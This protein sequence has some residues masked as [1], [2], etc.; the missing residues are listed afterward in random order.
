MRSRPPLLRT[1]FLLA[2]AFV[3]VVVLVLCF[4]RI[5]RVVIGDG[6]FVGPSRAVRAPRAGVLAEVL[7]EPGTRVEAGAVLARLDARGFESER[8]GLAAER[9]GAQTR[10]AELARERQ[11]V[12]DVRHP[13]ERAEMERAQRAAVLVLEAAEAKE[14]R[15]AEL[16][17]QGLVEQ[18]EFEAAK[19]A[20]EL[21]AVELEQAAAARAARP[22]LEADELAALDARAK[23]IGHELEE[24][25]AREAD[26]ARRA[27]ENELVAPVAGCVLGA[28]RAELLGRAVLEGDE[29]LRVAVA[30]VDAFVA[31]VDDLGRARIAAGQPAKL[32][33]SGYPWLVHGTVAAQVA[34][35][36]DRPDERGFLVRLELADDREIGPLYEGMT[37][38]A[39]IATKERVSIAWLV[40]E[41][42]FG[43]DAK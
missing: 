27:G 31:H 41:E 15:Y 25:A 12:A 24:I 21:A 30:G 6:A 16:Q 18:V 32:R 23:T 2:G 22:A 36:A 9:A 40:L 1:V 34:F 42:L 3:V 35:V 29:L 17:G 14:K 43:L 5:D 39:R 7:V 37:G 19:L 10:L 8:A 38:R 28:P 11:H 13:T 33:L 26:L 4:V 20:R